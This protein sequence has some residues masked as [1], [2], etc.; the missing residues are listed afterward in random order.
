[1]FP[2][3]RVQL[4]QGGTEAIKYLGTHVLSHVIS[5]FS[6]RKMSRDS[7]PF[8]VIEME[9]YLFRHTD[10]FPSPSFFPR[11]TAHQPSAEDEGVGVRSSDILFL[12]TEYSLSTTEGRT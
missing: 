9:L 3:S 5:E 1:M 11:G 7:V 6:G 12:T 10:F 8:G 4:R 2:L